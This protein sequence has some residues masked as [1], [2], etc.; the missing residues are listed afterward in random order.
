MSQLSARLI[1]F[2]SK[3]GQVVSAQTTWSNTYGCKVLTITFATRAQAQAFGAKSVLMAWGFYSWSTP[4]NSVQLPLY[5]A[6]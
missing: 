1:K 2:A 4:N 3:F 6:S 5:Q